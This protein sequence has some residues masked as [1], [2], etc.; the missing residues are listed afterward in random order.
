M[1]VTLTGTGG[2][3][4][5]L[6][7]FGGLTNAINA[8]RGTADLSG[9]SI[10]SAGVGTDHI[11]AQH[12]SNLQG[13]IDGLYTN[14]ATYR[15]Q[16]GT[17]LTQIKGFAQGDLTTMFVNDGSVQ[18]ANVN[19]CLKTL[20]SQMVAG[21]HTVKGNT[22]SAS[23]SAG[24][25]TGNGA[26]LG[27]IVAPNGTTLQYV[28]PETLILT[29]ATDS[30]TSGSSVL[31]SETW[32]IVGA[33]S[34]SDPLNYDW[35]LGSATNKQTQTIDPAGSLNKLANGTFEAF[36]TNIPNNW[37]ITVGNAG[38]TVF[39]STGQ[40]RG[41]FC[42][43][44]LGNGSELTA[45]TQNFNDPTG[46][47][48]QLLPSTVYAVN[49]FV[50]VSATPS[51]GVLKIDLTDSSG[52]VINDAA[53]TPNTIT[54]AL[55]GISTTYVSFGGYFRTPAVMNAAGYKIRVRLST[56]LDNSKFVLIDDLALA[57][58]TPAYTNGPYIAIFTGSV[59]TVIGD[60]YTA[61]IANDFGGNFQKLFERWFQMRSNSLQLPYVLDGSQ[62]IADTL[63]A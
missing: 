27:S 50:K 26:A 34:E 28:N 11:E 37:V 33:A 61:T 55:T 51:A 10:V 18:T 24:T 47:T 40:F 63:V 57:I 7:R 60:S 2:L 44:I 58:P 5:R 12:Q 6:G 52:T 15:G 49:S 20:I 59:A 62:D 23:I 54:L 41:S 45:L 1:A 29:A 43:K 8:F 42:L 38:T 56:A 22:V 21:S 32:N 17:F 36:T 9:A 14:L 30:Q 13:S 35:P 25:N 46:T 4:T 31:G 3:M 16:H 53:G 48:Y 19:L 39:Q